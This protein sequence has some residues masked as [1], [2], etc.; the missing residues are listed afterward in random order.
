MRREDAESLRYTKAERISEHSLTLEMSHTGRNSRVEEYAE[1]V[2][3][4]LLHN[5]MHLNLSEQEG[6]YELVAIK[7]SESK[8]DLSKSRGLAEG[9]VEWRTERKP[10]TDQDDD[11][12][13]RINTILIRLPQRSPT[14]DRSPGSH[15]SSPVTWARDL[16]TRP[17]NPCIRDSGE[18]VHHHSAWELSTCTKIEL[19]DVA[20]Q[21]QDHPGPGQGRTG[22]R[23]ARSQH[24]HMTQ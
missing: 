7:W 2:M 5:E 14:T 21:S 24:V 4:G 10:P 3:S 16:E 8:F 15:A 13:W 6:D 9:I 23:S 1:I 17:E 19:V 20:V 18:G 22:R 12:L 11:T